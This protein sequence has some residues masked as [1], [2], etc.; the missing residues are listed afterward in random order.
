MLRVSWLGRLQGRLFASRCVKLG[1]GSWSLMPKV[2]THA[3]RLYSQNVPVEVLEVRVLLSVAGADPGAPPSPPDLGLNNSPI[4]HDDGPYYAPHGKAIPGFFPSV[5]QNDV[6]GAVVVS[7]GLPATVPNTPGGSSA[8]YQISN[9]TNSSSASATIIST[10][11]APSDSAGPSYAV[12]SPDPTTN[13]PYSMP[14]MPYMPGIG[15]PP[16]PPP[17][18]PAHT[19]VVGRLGLA[20]G[21]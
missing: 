18:G 4:A 2:A 9:G 19:N 13:V 16:P 3:R 20:T 11:Q 14:Y 6:A 7:G 21:N 17:A 5:L 15:F 8:I 1:G 10:N 12:I